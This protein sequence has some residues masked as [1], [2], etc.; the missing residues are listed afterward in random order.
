MLPASVRSQVTWTTPSWSS[1]LL[2]FLIGNLFCNF[3]LV[4]GVICWAFRAANIS[5]IYLAAIVAVYYAWITSTKAHITGWRSGKDSFLRLFRNW[6]R[7]FD[8][9]VIMDGGIEPGKQYVFCCSPHGIHGFGTG[10]LMDEASPFFERFPFLRGKLVRP[11]HL[12]SSFK[13][14]A[15]VEPPR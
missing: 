14:D 6:I 12:S 10:V 5:L 9:S 13:F 11:G 7:Y 15:L 8:A 1:T 4:V 3:L 2:T